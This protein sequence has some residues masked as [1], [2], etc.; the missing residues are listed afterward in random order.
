[1]LRYYANQVVLGFELDPTRFI[2][3]TEAPVVE[4]V[5]EDDFAAAPNTFLIN[6]FPENPPNV[7]IENDE[8]INIHDDPLQEIIPFNDFLTQSVNVEP[9]DAPTYIPPHLRDVQQI[10]QLNLKEISIYSKLIFKMAVEYEIDTAI[11]KNILEENLEILKEL[12]M[13]KKTIKSLKE[14]NKKIIIINKE[15]DKEI[16]KIREEKLKADE[17][18]QLFLRTYTNMSIEMLKME[19]KLAKYENRIW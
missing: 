15:T 18:G 6:T 13:A 10:D 11:E 2:R 17:N 7:D 19:E 4:N 5:I 12:E 3:T 16:N 14:L 9:T 1:V 8:P